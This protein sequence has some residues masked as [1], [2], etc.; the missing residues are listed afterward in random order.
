MTPAEIIAQVRPLVQDTRTP[1]RYTDAV[2]LGFVNQ[3]LKRMAMVR[4]DLFTVFETVATTPNTVVQRLPSKATR[5][6]EVYNVD[7]GDVITEVDKNAL[8]QTYPGW[9]SAPAGQPVNYVRHVR[10]PTSFF[11]YPAPADGVSLVTE[12][13]VAPDDYTINQEIDLLSDTYLPSLVDGTVFLSQSIDD[14]HVSTGRAKLF[15]DSFNQTLVAGL[16]TRTITDTDASGLDPRQV[17]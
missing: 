8:D 11:L 5:L 7:G 16:Q 9:R 14:E 4:P 3:A 13:A 15:L 2:L 10:N 6:V 1:Y 17:V 12:Y